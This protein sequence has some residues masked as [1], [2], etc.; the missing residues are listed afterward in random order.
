VTFRDGARANIPVTGRA[1]GRPGGMTLESE[2]RA[3]AHDYRTRVP[4]PGAPAGGTIMTI[5]AATQ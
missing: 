1:G 2:I 4:G 3:A 5:M